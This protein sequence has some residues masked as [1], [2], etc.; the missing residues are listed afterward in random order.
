MLVLAP[1]AQPDTSATWLF[2]LSSDEVPANWLE[3]VQ[4]KGTLAEGPPVPVRIQV[5]LEWVS[6]VMNLVGATQS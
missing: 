3:Q 2:W 1:A 4:E 6:V 5:D